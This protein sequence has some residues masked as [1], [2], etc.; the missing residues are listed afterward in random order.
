MSKPKVV[1][2][3]AQGFSRADV[4]DKESLTWELVPVP[5]LLKS[6]I[7]GAL[8][9]ALAYTGGQAEQAGKLLG[10]TP[11]VMGYMMGT[12]DI[13]GLHVSHK[14]PGFKQTRRTSRDRH[15]R[16]AATKKKATADL[17]G[18]QV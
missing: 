6:I 1:H 9:N 7:R 11:R 17:R 14:D 16:A 4:R 12:H 8:L 10:L 15:R 18:R 3:A 13:P 2:S 5:E